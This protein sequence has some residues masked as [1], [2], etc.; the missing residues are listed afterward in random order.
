ATA[1]RFLRSFAISYNRSMSQMQ[2]QLIEKLLEKK[3]YPGLETLVAQAELE[4]LAEI[5]LQFR[6]LDKLVVFKLMDAVR[7][8]ELYERLEFKEKYH[9][10]CGFS[11]QAIAPVLEPLT[12][13]QRLVFVALPREFYDRMFRRLLSERA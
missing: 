8:M 1:R 9:L 12:A 13:V 4:T 11:L 10:L 3:D 5:W 7:A 2:F 6:P